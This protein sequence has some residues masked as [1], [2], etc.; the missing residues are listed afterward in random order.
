MGPY[1]RATRQHAISLLIEGAST[2]VVA[3]RVGVSQQT[4]V[5]WRASEPKHNP[6]NRGGHPRKLTVRDDLII[7]RHAAT[8]RHPT[9]AAI[10]RV[11]R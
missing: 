1:T 5:R 8:G 11:L 7:A 2:R 4:V 6:V 3:A 10:Q 9:A